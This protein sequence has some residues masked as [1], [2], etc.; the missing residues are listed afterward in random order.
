[1]VLSGAMLFAGG[2]LID[3]I[4][5]LVPGGQAFSLLPGIGSVIFGTLLI[6]FGAR[7]PRMLLG[8]L[9]PAR[10]GHDRGGVGDDHDSG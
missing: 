5:S 7:L 1:M 2:T 6:T 9:G 10:R 8:A 4:E 3:L